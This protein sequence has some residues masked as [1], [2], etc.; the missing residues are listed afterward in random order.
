MKLKIIPFS[1]FGVLYELLAPLG[2]KEA[3]ASLEYSYA[4]L[5]C[6]CDAMAP[7]RPCKTRRNKEII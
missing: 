7:L 3:L 2:S 6:W 4:T 5:D 1:T